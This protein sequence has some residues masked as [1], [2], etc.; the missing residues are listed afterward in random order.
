M[1]VTE[2]GWEEIPGGRIMN[3]TKSVTEVINECKKLMSESTIR[4]NI[5]IDGVTS[6]VEKYLQELSNSGLGRKGSS[7]R[8]D[9]MSRP[10]IMYLWHL[11]KQGKI[12]NVA[13]LAECGVSGKFLLVPMYDDEGKPTLQA[14]IPIVASSMYEPEGEYQV[15]RFVEELKDVDGIDG[16]FI[17]RSSDNGGMYVDECSKV[18]YSENLDTGRS[19][20]HAFKITTA[21]GDEYL[22]NPILARKNIITINDEWYR[23]VQAP[24][25]LE[26]LNDP[27]VK[28]ASD[29]YITQDIIIPIIR[30][31]G[32]SGKF[33]YGNGTDKPE[34]AYRAS[35]PVSRFMALASLFVSHDKFKDKL[36]EDPDNDLLKRKAR[37]SEWDMIE[38]VEQTIVEP[39]KN[40]FPGED[41]LKVLTLAIDMFILTL[42]GIEAM[43]K[44]NANVVNLVLGIYFYLFGTDEEV[45]L[46]DDPN[47]PSSVLQDTLGYRWLSYFISLV[48]SW[49]N[50]PC[51]NHKDLRRS[52]NVMY[53][54]EF[55]CV[56]FNDAHGALAGAFASL[57]AG[58]YTNT[59]TVPARRKVDGKTVYTTKQM[60]VF[61]NHFGI[62]AYILYDFDKYMY[63]EGAIHYRGQF[64]S[65]L[66]TIAIYNRKHLD[67]K[68][69]GNLGIAPDQVRMFEK[70]L[71]SVYGYGTDTYWKLV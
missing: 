22:E 63:N 37:V 19:F 62:S 59:V 15:I 6:V 57:A 29:G 39:Y 1:V 54:L 21:N 50:V 41:E 66:K 67:N 4:E 16:K 34:T 14:I 47:T 36:A 24:H 71:V 33:I 55:T 53:N 17:F 30:G 18:E 52:H 61:K 44:D 70:F 28:K 11:I 23:Y 69:T 5:N 3:N 7:R 40:M 8:N 26:E 12:V 68:V 32:A 25:G 60:Q 49:E 51:V 20:D 65:Q 31:I 13:S 27:N 56:D 38:G 10:I 48:D 35:I 42:L 9:L 46:A 45:K 2:Y 58:Q 64:I 43:Q